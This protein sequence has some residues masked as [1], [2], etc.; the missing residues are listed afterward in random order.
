MIPLQSVKTQ[1]DENAKKGIKTAADGYADYSDYEPLSPLIVDYELPLS[2]RP[3]VLLM[4]R[5]RRKSR[6]E[7]RK[8]RREERGRRRKETTT[9]TIRRMLNL[10]IVMLIW[11]MYHAKC[12]HQSLRY[13]WNSLYLDLLFFGL[14]SDFSKLLCGYNGTVFIAVRVLLLR[15]RSTI[16]L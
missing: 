6:R 3:K 13:T 9:R 14:V 2:V 15:R 10:F 12:Y 4:R 5:N 1:E 8:S 16:M 7:E 11:L